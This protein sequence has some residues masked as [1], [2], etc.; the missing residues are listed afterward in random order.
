MKFERTQSNFLKLT[1]INDIV[2]IVKKCQIQLFADDTV[3]YVIGDRPD[4]IMGVLNEELQILVQWLNNNSLK[5]NISKTKMMM[6]KRKNSRLNFTVNNVVKIND[7]YIEKVTQYKYL[8]CVID[9]NL[10]FSEHYKFITSKIAKKTNVLGRMS[11]DLSS[12][13]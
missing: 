4:E 11:K 2:N 8:G 9:E 13:V 1:Y 5:L 3:I 6:I 10:S 12:F 7:E